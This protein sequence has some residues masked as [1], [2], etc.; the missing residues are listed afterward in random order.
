MPA[1]RVK[2][3]PQKGTVYEIQDIGIVIGT[4][5]EADM[6]LYDSKLEEYHA[7]IY[8]MGEMYFLRNLAE[9]GFT[10]VNDEPVSEVMLREGDLIRVGST[11]C[12]FDSS[13]ATIRAV[14]ESDYLLDDFAFDVNDEDV[15]NPSMDV[16]EGTSRLQRDLDIIR[17]F[18]EL[19]SEEKGAKTY[20][21][22]AVKYITDT[23]GCDFTTIVMRD[24]QRNRFKV[25]A[26][27]A[28]TNITVK[29]AE[30]IVQYSLTKAQPLLLADAKGDKR[31]V[32]NPIVQQ[33]EVHS[34]IC[35]PMKVR[36]ESSGCLYLGFDGFNGI[37][38]PEDLHLATVFGMQIGLVLSYLEYYSKQNETIHSVVKALSKAVDLHDPLMMGHSERVG[39]FSQ[40]IAEFM[41][42]SSEQVNE[43]YL[44]G[45]LHDIGRIVQNDDIV[46]TQ[47]AINKGDVRAIIEHVEMGVKILGEIVGL[48][49]LIPIVESHHEFFDGTGLPNQL[50]GDKIPLG[51]RIVCA[52][53]VFDEY[54]FPIVPEI[55][56]LS[57]SS[58]LIQLKLCAGTKLDPDVV[59]AF[60]IAY[61][62]GALHPEEH[63]PSQ[64]AGQ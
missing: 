30:P 46:E 62:K 37:F 20:I 43:I 15:L 59:N 25:V 63:L 21:E 60:L 18:I 39:K 29:V 35:V 9:K 28:R 16:P 6:R 57:A 10:L 1:I 40:S 45:L 2:N 48:E 24:A 3:G 22:K 51:G 19:G 53:N 23:I 36:D 17:D 38:S 31:F 7:R 47:R 26:S 4:A 41:S 11:I 44:G 64:K 27:H 56:P 50:K 49:H 34:V 33:L 8:R 55:K 42:L 12:V 58:A 54:L 14:E 61:R 32:H 52:A 5:P 13:R